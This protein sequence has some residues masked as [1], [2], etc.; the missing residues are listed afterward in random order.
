MKNSVEYSNLVQLSHFN[1][2]VISF[3][4]FHRIAFAKRSMSILKEVNKKKI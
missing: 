3:V 2:Y 4:I 1:Y